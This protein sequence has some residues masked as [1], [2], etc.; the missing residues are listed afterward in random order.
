LGARNFPISYSS[1][2]HVTTEY[3]TTSFAT[4]AAADDTT[5]GRRLGKPGA[6][7]SML[8][9]TTGE[10]LLKVTAGSQ[11][12][13]LVRLSS[14]KCTIGS[15]G[16]CTLRIHG[17]EIEPVQCVV[18]HGPQKSII[19]RWAGSMLLNDRS[20]D[21]APLKTGD[22]LAFGSVEFQVMS[23]PG[24]PADHAGT[25]RRF[26]GEL[27]ADKRRLDQLAARLEL[28]NRQGRRRLRAAVAKLR[29]F[30][31]RMSELEGRRRLHS[32]EE[33][34]LKLEQSR[35]ETLTREAQLRLEECDRRSQALA[36]EQRSLTEQGER[37][38]ALAK[39]ASQ[40]RQAA[41][42]ALSARRADL[43]AA[44]ARHKEKEADLERR[45]AQLVADQARAEQD[46]AQLLRWEAD[47]KEQAT[48]AAQRTAECAARAC[49]LETR[50]RALSQQLASLA[51]RQSALDRLAGESVDRHATIDRE[52]A[53]RERTLAAH[54][55]ELRIAAAAQK[56][57][58]TKMAAWETSL[59][60]RDAA[61]AQKL[62]ALVVRE[63]ETADKIAEFE[64]RQTAELALR[65]AHAQGEATQTADAARSAQLAHREAELEAASQRLADLRREL[66]RREADLHA[67]SEALQRQTVAVE[68]R[69]AEVAS[70]QAECLSQGEALAQ[71]RLELTAESEKLQA[72]RESLAKHREE[73]AVRCEALKRSWAEL[74]ERER[75]LE[76]READRPMS[77]PLGSIPSSESTAAD[78]ASS[79]AA[80]LSHETAEMLELLNSRLSQR[81]AEIERL[82]AELK[83]ARDCAEIPPHGV[84]VPA[85]EV[86]EPV[87]SSAAE[88]E[89]DAGQPYDSTS[90]T[91]SLDE[92]V[93]TIEHVV[94]V[95]T[96][97]E[98]S[99]AAVNAP[100][101]D[102]A[103][104]A[105]DHSEAADD[106][107]V[108]PAPN[109][110]SAGESAAD[111]LRRLGLA[112]ALDDNH[113]VSPSVDEPIRRP[114]L[115]AVVAAPS[116]EH[117]DDSLNDYMA[118]LFQ[119]LGVQRGEQPAASP[120]P[121]SEP[122]RPVAA[123]TENQDTPADRLAA[124]S[125]R[126]VAPLSAAEFKARSVAA[127]R[128][129]DLSTLRELAN[130]NARTAVASHQIRTGTKASRWKASLAIASAVVTVGA[131]VAA[132]LGY[133]NA[134]PIALGALVVTALFGIKS[135]K[136]R[137]N[138][139]TTAR[140]LDDVLQKSGVKTP[141][142]D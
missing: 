63:T 52:L 14:A 77:A 134:L 45:L 2:P 69:H 62:A 74:V 55:Q 120:P 117:E 76:E 141:N 64:L 67:S 73:V 105:D 6:T 49:D 86:A 56:Q 60:E 97:V 75:R 112:S 137:R 33:T 34:Q 92:S 93:E 119:R 68:A 95:E 9:G 35:L 29:K 51:E 65:T 8:G 103:H 136:L 91:A 126:S 44:E 46:S 118:Q 82:L 16:Y 1:V 89:T 135:I 24:K 22:R 47:L 26:G 43:E 38:R 128:K 17:A 27:Q 15:A 109:R 40:D 79:E 21:D 142:N 13:R 122:S 88:V 32:Q 66:E 12:G 104:I 129:T 81:D 107:A 132:P 99:A 111:V 41:Q 54:E 140:S 5:I 10:F 72:D 101:D 100:L 25:V 114:E 116:G 42:A 110:L 20:F 48:A 18:L 90:T 125:E 87:E 106:E 30:Q 28:A 115:P 59:A 39:Q 108:E 70:S 31:L 37:L 121:R 53:E 139:K 131:C 50:E 96:S 124:P 85:S 80:R 98:A 11:I 84:V 113:A 127:E 94:E 102:A 3:N 36:E 7:S 71:A 133:P 61:F 78:S 19:R 138:V 123:T 4:S 23:L 130:V 83:L 58:E 57:I